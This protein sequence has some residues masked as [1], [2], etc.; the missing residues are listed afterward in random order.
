VARAWL[1]QPI[2]NAGAWT[3]LKHVGDRGEELFRRVQPLRQRQC[4]R[5]SDELEDVCGQVRANVLGLIL[6]QDREQRRQCGSGET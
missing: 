6:G 5:G 2:V 1:N 3:W 4:P